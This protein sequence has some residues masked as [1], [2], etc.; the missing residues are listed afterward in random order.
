MT[1]HL[2]RS[3]VTIGVVLT[4][5][6]GLLAIRAASAW[7]ASSAPLSVAPVSVGSLT[8][9]LA[10]E[11]AR[12]AALQAQLD[13]LVT[14][15][16]ELTGAFEEAQARISSDA[17]TATDLRDRLAAAEKKLAT[18]TKSLRQASG[19]QVAASAPTAA[20][21][22]AVAT[23]GGEREHEEEPEHDD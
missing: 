19:V 2:R 17:T 4:L 21:A 6:L 16:T 11:Q 7:T 8:D 10:T 5:V 3:L 9:D 18:L 1:L 14:R 22:P 20:A 13:E 23:G 15:S 12:S